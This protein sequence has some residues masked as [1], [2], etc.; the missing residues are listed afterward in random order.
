MPA[1]PEFPPWAYIRSTELARLC[2]VSMQTVWN[3]RVRNQGPPS[4]Q[5][6]GRRHWY[7][8]ADV[9]S[10]LDKGTT[11]PDEIIIEWL[12]TRYLGY[13]PAADKLQAIIEQLE[14]ADIL[15]RLKKPR[16]SQRQPSLS[17]F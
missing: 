3:W 5:D 9:Q 15:P 2:G 17:V 13:R 1:N 11:K 10:W 14:M 6:R 7:R 4:V 8:L 12:A 16:L